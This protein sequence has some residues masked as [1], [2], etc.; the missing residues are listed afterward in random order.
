MKDE[1]N[2]KKKQ[3]KKAETK[4]ETKEEINIAHEILS[5]ILFMIFAVVFVLLINRYVGQRT[6][7]NGPSMDITLASGDNLWLNKFTYHFQD[8]ERFDIVVFPVPNGDH[9]IKRVIGLPGETVRIEEDGR[10]YIK[11][12][13]QDYEL[14]ED[15]YAYYN[16][17]VYEDPNEYENI[18]KE[19]TLDEDEYFVM[20]DNRNV[21]LDSRAEE[22]GTIE[23]ERIIGKTT[24]RIWPLSRFG[25][26][27]DK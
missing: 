5:T 12:P 21:S 27:E 25:K 20:G 1:Q 8:P 9:Y 15:K 3:G 7:V 14:L 11:E 17:G 10:I 24:F 19:W 2:M 18:A 23:R 6:P 16:N 22:V 4:A 26:I 13:D